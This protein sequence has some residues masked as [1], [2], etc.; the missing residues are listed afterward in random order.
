MK[1]LKI[2]HRNCLMSF[3]MSLRAQIFNELF[4]SNNEI[5]NKEQMN[6]TPKMKESRCLKFSP[7]GTQ[8]LP[9]PSWK[10][11]IIVWHQKHYWTVLR[12]L[13][14]PAPKQ[15]KIWDTKCG[16]AHTT[17][18]HVALAQV[19]RHF[20][21][22]VKDKSQSHLTCGQETNYPILIDSTCEKSA[23]LWCELGRTII[24]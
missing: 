24:V 3:R 19:G 10:V 8:T 7:V 17:N 4:P 21:Y 14:T 9:W 20:H 11:L 5:Q 23:F 2:Y 16:I 18:M 22:G 13:R 15:C 6:L 1:L 12:F